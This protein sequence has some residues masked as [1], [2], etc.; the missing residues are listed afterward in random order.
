MNTMIKNVKLVEV[1]INIVTVS[2]NKQ[3]LKII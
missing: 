2:L 1:N 3:I